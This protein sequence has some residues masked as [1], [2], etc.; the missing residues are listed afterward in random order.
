MKGHPEADSSDIIEFVS[1][2]ED[3]FE[4]AVPYDETEDQV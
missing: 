3:F 1:C 2:Q 4:D